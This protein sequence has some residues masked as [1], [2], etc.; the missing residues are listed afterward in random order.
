MDVNPNS[1]E[2]ASASFLLMMAFGVLLM[3][4]MLS[5]LADIVMG[6]GMMDKLMS[7][8]GMGKISSLIA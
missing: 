1:N 8:V 3:V 2:S 5:M 7:A 6:I 4:I